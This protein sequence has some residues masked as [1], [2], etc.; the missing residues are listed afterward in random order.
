MARTLIST[1]TDARLPSGTVKERVVGL[2]VWSCAGQRSPLW[3]PGAAAL[4]TLV[5]APWGT[6]PTM[7]GHVLIWSD[8]CVLCTETLQVK[9]AAPKQA[10]WPMLD[11]DLLEPLTKPAMVGFCGGRWEVRLCF[12]IHHISSSWLETRHSGVQW[13]LV[14]GV[15]GEITVHCASLSWALL[16]HRGVC[17]QS[18]H[19][20]QPCAVQVGTALSMQSLCC[21]MDLRCPSNTRFPLPPSFHRDTC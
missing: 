17:M 16:R 10:L 9:V 14:A 20:T 13:M 15:S 21:R 2:L 5:R 1:G 6:L 19:Q 8:V 18:H 12:C 3:C 4:P 7:K 11:E